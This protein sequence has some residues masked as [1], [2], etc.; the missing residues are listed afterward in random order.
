MTGRRW[1]VAQHQRSPD[2]RELPFEAAFRGT[3]RIRPS[4]RE[5]LNLGP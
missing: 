5:T 3:L 1:L 4:F 2:Y